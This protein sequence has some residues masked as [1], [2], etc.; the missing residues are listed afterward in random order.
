MSAG[1]IAFLVAISSA[2]WVFTKLQNKTG[3]GNNRD[4]LVGAVVVFALAFVVVFSLAH[5]L[6]H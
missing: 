1:I 2:T 5:A 4:A 3:Y 6:M